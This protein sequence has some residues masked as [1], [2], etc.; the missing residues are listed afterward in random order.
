MQ[1]AWS[2]RVCR[3]KPNLGRQA[4]KAHRLVETDEKELE[5]ASK[6]DDAYHIM[7][8]VCSKSCK[9]IICTVAINGVPTPMELDTDA[10]YS[11][12]TQTTNQ[13]ITEQKGVRDPEPL[14]LKVRS[15]S[16]QLIKVLG[17]LPVVVTHGEKQCELYVLVVDGEGPDLLD[18]CTKGDLLSG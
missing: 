14:D 8:A 13:K 10:A 12:I 15:Y 18:G 17:Q 9:P 6:E 4:K 2:S 7:F 1:E 11:V 3:L 16:S 5:S